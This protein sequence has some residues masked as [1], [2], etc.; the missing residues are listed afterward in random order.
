MAVITSVLLVWLL[1]FAA[2]T[3][4]HFQYMQREPE[5]KWHY[6]FYQAVIIQEEEMSPALV[7]IPMGDMG[8]VSQW[9]HQGQMWGEILCSRSL[10]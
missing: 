1:L 8:D 10:K 7:D 4:G 6:T 3:L 2:M 5:A 9:G